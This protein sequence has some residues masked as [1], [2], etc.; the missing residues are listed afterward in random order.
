MQSTSTAPACKSSRAKPPS[1]AAPARREPRSLTPE[2]LRRRAQLRAVAECKMNRDALA[3]AGTLET[4]HD[5][6][7]EFLDT[8]DTNT[9]QLVLLKL[10]LMEKGEELEWSLEHFGEFVM[11]DVAG[12][13]Y[14]IKSM[15]SL[16]GDQ[17][18]RL[19]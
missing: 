13:L 14:L 18:I 1:P 10:E 19:E 17:L 4:L 8:H 5:Q 3:I 16:F 15:T 11:E 9:P 7:D 2:V 12:L 6:L